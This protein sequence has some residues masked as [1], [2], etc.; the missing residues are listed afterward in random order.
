MS[1]LEEMFNEC[2]DI[3]LLAEG[4]QKK[5]YKCL[6]PEFGHVVIKTGDY[7]YISS[8]D[9]IVR[10]VE[11][12]REINSEYYPKNFE[13][14]IDTTAHKFIIIEEYIDAEEL[15]N[16]KSRFNTDEE[17]LKLLKSLILGFNILWQQRIVHRDIK[18]ANILITAN[19]E[20][21]IIDLGIARFLNLTSL[22]DTLASSG[23]RTPIYAAP[24]QIRNKKNM[25][26]ERTDFFLLALLA[27]ELILGHHPFDP[28][29]VGN[30]KSIMENIL[31]GLYA[32]PGERHDEKLLRFIT[33]SL[34][35]KP[36]KRFRTAKEIMDYLNMG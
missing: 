6:H 29:Y 14:L 12:L 17:I 21:K 11:T 2:S 28:K 18:P 30:Q 34:E 13:F 5:V 3:T 10:E 9:R 24:E 19:N 20:P 22:T 16:V 35:V 27:L 7:R 32:L 33:K 4:G 26:N 15:T 36:Y 8:L 25:I 31:D 1:I 23:P